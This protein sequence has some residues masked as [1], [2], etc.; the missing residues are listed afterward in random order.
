MGVPVFTCRACGQTVHGDPKHRFCTCGAE[1]TLCPHCDLWTLHGQPV[2]I[3]VCGTCGGLFHRESGIVAPKEAVADLRPRRYPA[4]Q[5]V[6]RDT[7]AMTFEGQITEGPSGER[8]DGEN[9][10]PGL[11][12]VDSEGQVT[13][14]DSPFIRFW[15]GT[16]WQSVDDLRDHQPHWLPWHDCSLR[17]WNGARFTETKWG[18][19]EWCEIDEGG[20]PCDGDTPFVRLRDLAGGNG[21]FG[22]AQDMRTRDVSWYQWSDS[23]DRFWD[24]A[25]WTE[26]RWAQWGQQDP[27]IR[28]AW[29]G[30]AIGPGSSQHRTT[31]DLIEQPMH[32]RLALPVPIEP[33]QVGM[34]TK[35]HP[36]T[37]N[38]RWRTLSGD[39]QHSRPDPRWD[40]QLNKRRRLREKGRL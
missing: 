16:R 33:I 15:T 2:P 6:T 9:L 4:P 17:Y 23:L 38:K 25:K 29:I 7:P 34:M 24:G 30:A 19:W 27:A 40:S 1:Y 32:W 37:E 10:K 11:Y 21:W 5:T 28:E 8:P 20:A 39:L 35:L 31:S 22:S 13:E 18:S 36:P 26:A 14:G 12:S 3:V